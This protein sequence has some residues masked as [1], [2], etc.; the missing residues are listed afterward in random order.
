MFVS[1][2]IERL[3]HCT[4]LLFPGIAN[5]AL[6]FALNRRGLYA[7]IGGGSF[8]QLGLMLAASGLNE[9]WAHQLSLSAYLV[10]RQKMKLNEALKLL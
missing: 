9:Q 5:E 10:S 8:Q 3:P 4:T 7:S 2:G 6:L 1:K